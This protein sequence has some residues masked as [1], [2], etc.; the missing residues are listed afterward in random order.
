VPAIVPPVAVHD[1]ALVELQVN[2]EVPPLAIALL[3]AV[4]VAVGTGL[5]VTD[6]E[7]VAAAAGL[8][9]PAPVHVREY[10]VFAVNAPVLWLPLVANAPVQPPEAVQDVALAEL[11]FSIA[12]PPLLT[13]VGDAVIDAAGAG[14]PGVIGADP[15][16][17]P[18]QAARSSAA[19][20]AMTGAIAPIR[21]F[22]DSRIMSAAGL[23]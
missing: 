1:V 14:G 9:P 23:C 13:A 20:I 5:A 18:P 19:P 21:V 6:T 11:Q 10:A 7:I 22:S 12:A 3:L 15:D 8:V 4:S 17:D 2:V 16:P